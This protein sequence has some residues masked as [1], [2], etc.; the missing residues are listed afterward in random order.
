MVKR[1]SMTLALALLGCTTPRTEILVVT[2]TDLATPSELDEMRVDVTGPGGDMMSSFARF[3]GGEPPPP[4][5]LGLVHDGNRLGPYTIVARGFR[6]GGVVVE[7]RA[8]VSF[9]PQ[10]TVLLRIDLDRDCIGVSCASGE[11]C[12]AGACRDVEVAP[13][14]LEDWTGQVPIAPIGDGGQEPPRDGGSPPSDAGCTPADEQ[15]NERDDDC[16]GSIDEDFDLANDPAHCGACDNVCDAGAR[17]SAGCSSGACTLECEAGWG[18]CDD[19]AS[20][21][22]EADLGEPETCGSCGTRCRPPNRECCD[23]SCC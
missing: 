12:A 17:S 3:D 10:R 21:G 8:E 22:C 20:N 1:A 6:A 16:D 14:E 7:R 5:V 19:D 4:R 13:Q 9:Q 23:G 11:T 2:D 18:D 15:C